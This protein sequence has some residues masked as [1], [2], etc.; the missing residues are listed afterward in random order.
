M[1]EIEV[2][3]LVLDYT[4]YP[5]HYIEEYNV[6]QLAEALRAGI[7]LPPVIAEQD[8]FRVVDG[9]HR[10]PAYIKVYGLD[11]MIPVEFMTFA[12][13]GEIFKEAAKRNIKHGR[14]LTSWDLKRC[15]SLAED[16]E[17]EPEE[18]EKVLSIT[19]KTAER[20]RLGSAR[21]GNEVTARRPVPLKNTIRQMAG[22]TLTK[23]QE[24]TNKKL[25]GHA[26]AF[27]INQLVMLIRSDLLDSGNERLMKQL[28][29]LRAL[30]DEVL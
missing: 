7:E 5:R 9:F 21:V 20:L 3:K 8:T 16:F 30:L 14:K 12:K 10:I 1:P 19:T 2:S 29:D 15:L 11:V 22:K 23:E 24:E 18:I 17:I 13:D 26:Q 4:V 6:N 28:A 27:Y 25:G